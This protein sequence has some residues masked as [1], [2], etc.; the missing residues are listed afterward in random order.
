[1]RVEKEARK[2]SIFFHDGSSVKGVV[3][4]NPGERIIDFLNDAKEDFIALSQEGK[5][6]AMINKSSIKILEEL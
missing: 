4:I 3:Y 5:S 2:V 1:M 6:A